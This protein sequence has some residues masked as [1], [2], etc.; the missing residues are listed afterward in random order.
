MKTWTQSKMVH[1]TAAEIEAHKC[2]IEAAEPDS[3][4]GEAEFLEVPFA[5]ENRMLK[6]SYLAWVEMSLQ[7]KRGA[8][9]ADVLYNSLNKPKFVGGLEPHQDGKVVAPNNDTEDDGN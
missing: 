9:N 8:E 5:P 6:E 7:A 3:R 2:T 4:E 1:A